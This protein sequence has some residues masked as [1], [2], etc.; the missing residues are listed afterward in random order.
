MER[1]SLIPAMSRNNWQVLHQSLHIYVSEPATE[2]WP[3]VWGTAVYDKNKVRPRDLVQ[4][5]EWPSGM[6]AHEALG[7]IPT[8]IP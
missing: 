7:S 8:A 2:V 3:V 5:E 6:H 4:P 1:V